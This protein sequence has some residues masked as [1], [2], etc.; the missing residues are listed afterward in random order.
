MAPVGIVTNG[1]H[2]VDEPGSTAINDTPLPV[3]RQSVDERLDALLQTIREWDWRSAPVAARPTSA[4]AS[5]VL[6]TAPTTA[7]IPPAA[8]KGFEPPLVPPASVPSASEHTEASLL[9]PTA[10]HA[11]TEPLLTEQIDDT[12]SEV[13]APLVLEPQRLAP[14]PVLLALE[15]PAATAAQDAVPSPAD[16]SETL[17]EAMP[18]LRENPEGPTTGTIPAVEPRPNLLESKGRSRLNLL[19]LCLAAVAV[20]V[21]IIG[22]IRVVSEKSQ[23]PSLSGTTPT[24]AAPRPASHAFAPAHPAPITSAQLAMYKQYAQSLQAANTV[25]TK[26]LAG[27]GSTP[28]AADVEPVTSPYVTALNTYNI[29][30]AFI[31]WPASMET[32]VKADQSELGI[33]ANF[34]KNVSFVSPGEMGAWLAQL[35]DRA[36][37]VQATDNVVRQELG[38]SK[39][40]SFP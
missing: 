2:T 7:A 17:T 18:L 19:L 16:S 24:T 28:T 5:E 12:P 21:L 25:A 23:T 13:A 15:V 8:E 9:E 22:G 36:A 26:R 31:K 1:K 20:V 40:T 37:Q 10:Q 6:A 14:D 33:M 35:N 38:L 27:V 4:E 3:N 11:K 29:D 34:L 39:T 32:A 30:L